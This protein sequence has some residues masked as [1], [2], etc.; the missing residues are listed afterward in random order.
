M[1]AM[2]DAE[3][4]LLPF[5]TALEDQ[6]FDDVSS[7]HLIEG[8]ARHLM[9]Q[10]AIWREHGFGPIARSYRARLSP[11]EASLFDIDENG[12]LVVA[13]RTGARA[14]QRRSLMDALAAPCPTRSWN[15]KVLRGN[16]QDPD[17]ARFRPEQER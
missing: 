6:G 13:C 15:S 11:E 7:G 12:D 2:G 17:A 10:I 3:L 16:R 8:F 9:A 14:S 5:A 4:G 1:A